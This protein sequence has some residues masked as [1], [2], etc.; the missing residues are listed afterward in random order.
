[1]SQCHTDLFLG[2]AATYLKRLYEGGRLHRTG[3][4]CFPTVKQPHV[5][6]EA[7]V[8]VGVLHDSWKF[9]GDENGLG[10]IGNIT[11]DDLTVQ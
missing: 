5:H 6:S 9:G 11:G 1:M 2:G 4:S 3:V 10:E 7:G 8:A